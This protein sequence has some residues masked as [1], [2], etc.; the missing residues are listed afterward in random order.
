MTNSTNRRN[1]LL[2]PLLLALVVAVAGI[3]LFVMR[4]A[5]Y[6]QQRIDLTA[7]NAT[8]EA[9]KAARAEAENPVG[10]YQLTQWVV[11]GEEQSL[12]EYDASATLTIREDGTGSLVLR[13]GEEY[14]EISLTWLVC[15]RVLILDSEDIDRTG[16]QIE[17]G[18]TQIK[19]NEEGSS[20]VFE[21]IQ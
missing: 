15:G 8:L 5:D 6:Q 14:E 7:A 1:P 11:D 13:E 21:P 20:M 10:S 16:F 2:I 17:P 4:I 12:E 18:C 3:A 9:E 19:W